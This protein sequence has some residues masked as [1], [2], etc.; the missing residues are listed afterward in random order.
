MMVKN[1]HL[2]P[3]SRTIG[4]TTLMS[5][6]GGKL[7]RNGATVF[8]PVLVDKVAMSADGRKLLAVAR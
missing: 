3:A 2:Q 6:D 4:L 1:S 8:R 5:T 7:G